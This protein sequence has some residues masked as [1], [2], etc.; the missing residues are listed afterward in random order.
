MTHSWRRTPGM[1]HS[2]HLQLGPVTRL[3]RLRRSEGPARRPAAARVDIRARPRAGEPE[4][5]GRGPG[6]V[7]VPA[8]PRLAEERVAEPGVAEGRPAREARV[9]ERSVG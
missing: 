7:G 9:R 8:E 1:S 3:A 2:L 5:L 4:P 6:E